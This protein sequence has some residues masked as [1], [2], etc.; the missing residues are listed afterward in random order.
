MRINHAGVATTDVDLEPT[1]PIGWRWALIGLGAMVLLTP[2]GLIA[3]GA[4]F[5]EA[6]PNELNLQN[7]GLS[8]VP[9]GLRHYAG[10]WHNALFD[11]YTFSDDKHPIAGYLLSAGIGIVAIGVAIVAVFAALRVIRTRGA[12][13]S[14]LAE[15]SS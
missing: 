7:Y 9:T 11:G 5:G 6:A 8:R 15:V 2:L 4:A 14:D 13:G 3:P 10:F 12:R 1:R